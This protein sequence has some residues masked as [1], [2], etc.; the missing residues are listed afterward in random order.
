MAHAF[1]SSRS[2]LNVPLIAEPSQVV[3]RLSN[4]CHETARKRTLSGNHVKSQKTVPPAEL[5]R[6]WNVA[7]FVSIHGLDVNAGVVCVE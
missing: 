5:R 3:L 7:D 2:F 4:H 6:M 1:A